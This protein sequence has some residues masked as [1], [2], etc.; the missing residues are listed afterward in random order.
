MSVI[1]KLGTARRFSGNILVACKRGELETARL[2]A[3]DIIKIVEEIETQLVG[4]PF[5]Q[6]SA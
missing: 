1:S 3:E 5:L 6:S 2:L 4:A